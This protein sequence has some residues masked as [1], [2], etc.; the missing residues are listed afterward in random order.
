MSTPNWMNVRADADGRRRYRRRAS[1]HVPK[2]DVAIAVVMGS[3][4]TLWGV[5]SLASLYLR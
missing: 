4:L 1:D 5:N 2:W 3:L